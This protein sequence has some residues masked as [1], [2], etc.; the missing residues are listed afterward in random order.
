MLLFFHCP[1]LNITRWSQECG[2][3]VAHLPAQYLSWFAVT[4]SPSHPC[5]PVAQGNSQER[6]SLSWCQRQPLGAWTQLSQGLSL[7]CS[8]VSGDN[9]GEGVIYSHR[10]LIASLIQKPA[11]KISHSLDSTILSFL[12]SFIEV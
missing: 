4:S 9:W 12:M 7:S 6:R 2:S 8:R 3:H 5:F 10:L 11:L 1:G